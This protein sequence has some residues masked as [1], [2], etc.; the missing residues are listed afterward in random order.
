MGAEADLFDDY[1]L[2]T[3]YW[4]YLH[5]LTRL[6]PRDFISVDIIQNSMSCRFRA[7]LLLLILSWQF[8][9]M[10]SPLAVTE[11]SQDFTHVALHWQNDGHHHHDDQSFHVEDSDD[12][13]QTAQHQHLDSGIKTVCLLTTACFSIPCTLAAL[14]SMFVAPL[15]SPPFLE[16]PLRPPRL[17]A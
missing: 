11:R 6:M 8:L 10:V 12:A 16:G 2:K 7:F 14:P 1:F 5:S 13:S 15:G 3:R 9:S 17:S 4:R